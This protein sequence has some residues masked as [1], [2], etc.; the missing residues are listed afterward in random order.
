MD[1]HKIQ[2]IFFFL[3][4]AAIG[5]LS[6]LVLYPYLGVAFLAAIITIVF[7]P[8]H[9]RI[10]RILFNKKTISAIVSVILI[11]LLI[12]VPLF[13]VTILL[14]QEVSSLYVYLIP[15]GHGKEIVSEIGGFIQSLV[16]QIAPSVDFSIESFITNQYT[17]LSNYASGG[18]EWFARNIGTV[19]SGVFD[20]LLG[21]FILL[22]SLFYF[23]RD[24]KSFVKYMVDLSP[25]K[26]KYDI[27]IFEKAHTAI[28]SVIKG[29]I[30]IALLQGL[31]T[32]IGFAIFGVPSPV[33]WGFI[34]A[35]GSL[36]PTLGAGLVIIPAVIYV[37]M[38]SG[39]AF[40]IGLA[41]WG[42]I[43]VGLVDNFL[44]PFLIERGV[45]IHPFL[46]LLSIL[47]GIEFMGI[48]GF[49]AGPVIVSLLFALIEIM[50]IIVGK[51]LDN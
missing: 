25:L 11:S 37:F 24:G 30:I 41:L 19:F 14:F 17:N 9:K 38:Q 42:A 35:L 33:L 7:F 4:V 27:Q 20:S 46:I 31:L 48:L 5:V 6:I 10:E 18:L 3:L 50:P 13:I 44:A 39:A 40:A 47:G 36:L 12:L 23:L 21:V 2:T 49:F 22:L 1:A 43:I 8:I 45:K 32:G 34:A 28:N 16:S 15:Q 29:Y 26:D 51:K